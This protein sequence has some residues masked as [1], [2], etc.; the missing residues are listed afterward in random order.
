MRIGIYQEPCGG[1]LGGSEF[2]TAVLA[3][4]LSDRHAVDLIH[5][6]PGVTRDRLEDFFS[7]DLGAV[8]MR[9]EP[10]DH[11]W[12][13]AQSRG[14]NLSRTL[15]EWKA[16]LSRPY[17]L[18]VNTT[19]GVP[20]YCHAPVGVLYV[21]FPL[22]N[23]H[24]QWPWAA[25][26]PLT[27]KGVVARARRVHYERLW[28]QRVDSYRVKLAISGFSAEWAERYWGVPC[29][30]IPPPVAALFPVGEKQNTIATL[31][32]FVA[33]KKQRELVETFK[34]RVAPRLRDWSLTCV[35]GV[36]DA[37]VEQ[38]YYRGVCEVA[39]ITRCSLVPNAD[40]T[41][42]HKTLQRAKVFWHGAGADI[43]EHDNPGQQEH[44][45][46]A[47]VEAMAAG[48]VPVVINR[49]GQREIVEHGR[50]GFLCDTLEAVAD[51]TV[52]LATDHE[53]WLRMS[54][55]ARERAAYFGRDRFVDRFL[56]ALSPYLPG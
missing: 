54:Q 39:E 36:S 25:P 35:G 15:R 49:G 7:L 24:G 45:G 52:Q 41:T 29:D 30:V 40:R 28:R 9:Y 18:F 31:G 43:A 56:T 32:R 34:S 48:C 38:A 17:D 8:R 11:Q 19:H 13:P 4:A 46:I 42:V 10:P 12:I 3:Q 33:M 26:T 23:R 53:Q 20:P 5:H 22:F 21:L 16:G 27:P 55:A 47:T 6:H 51:R 44:F 1:G 2:V 37:E 14:W 50:S